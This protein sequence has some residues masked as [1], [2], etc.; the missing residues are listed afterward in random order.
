MDTNYVQ[1]DN[2]TPNKEKLYQG[3]KRKVQANRNDVAQNDGIRY[4]YDDSSNLK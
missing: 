4:D 3:N 1:K 2:T